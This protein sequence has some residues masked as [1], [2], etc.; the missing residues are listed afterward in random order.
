M[1]REKAMVVRHMR[2]IDVNPFRKGTYVNPRPVRLPGYRSA[3]AD[4]VLGH[5]A[6][7]DEEVLFADPARESAH[8]EDFLG[9]VLR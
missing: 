7:R 4:C 9:C 2:G 3:V 5:A 1:V 6:K 8:A